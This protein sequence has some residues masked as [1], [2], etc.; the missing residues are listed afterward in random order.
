[1]IGVLDHKWGV[2]P[3]QD[4]IWTQGSG[5]APRKAGRRL[6]MVLQAF[7]DESIGESGVWVLGGYVATAEAWAL[8]SKEWEEMLPFG[9][10][11]K[12]NLYHFKMNEMA[13]N[14]D[15]MQ[16]VPGFFRIIEK[17][18]SLAIS[19]KANIIDIQRAKNRIWIPNVD[20]SY[21]EA[22]AN[23]WKF[24][25]TALLDM[26]FHDRKAERIRQLIPPGEKIDFYFDERSEKG[27][28]IEGWEAFVSRR[29]DAFREFCE[30]TPRFEDDKI[31][32]PL[33]AA[34]FWAWW[35][36]KWE[37]NG[38]PEKSKN[39]DFGVCR[40]SEKSYLKLEISANEDEIA[41]IIKQDL[42][43]NILPSDILYDV[44]FFWNEKRL[45]NA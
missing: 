16:R 30:T 10:R 24:E 3:A 20:V 35:I 22:L 23:P 7:I 13:R 6:F 28:I 11:D 29:P 18:V 15:R 5:I 12:D 14:Q 39:C 17:Y 37:E 42:R 26:F 8:F 9:T 40:A 31:S 2:F 21:V 1:M 44:R 27:A 33:Q 4:R 43:K 32:P 25:F 38:T 36:R 34:D 41:N 19:C 45:Y